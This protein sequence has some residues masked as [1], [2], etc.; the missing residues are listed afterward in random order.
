MTDEY[1]DILDGLFHGSA[2][3]AFLDQAQEERG[4]PSVEGT[5]RRAFAYYEDE[6][7]KKN[8]A[9]KPGP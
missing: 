2:L 4:W 6:L 8:A 1:D 5:R 7:A 9:K 3:A